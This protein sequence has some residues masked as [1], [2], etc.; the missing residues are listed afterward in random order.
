[1]SKLP[2]LLLALLGHCTQAA[3]KQTLPNAPP[4]TLPPRA[5]KPHLRKAS[6][7]FVTGDFNGDQRSDTVYQHTFSGLTKTEADSL[8]DP[9][10]VDQDAVVEWLSQHDIRIF[11]TL[12]QQAQ[13]TL[14][15]GSGQG[16][17]CLLNIGDNN[18]DK[19]DELAFVVDY[20]DFSQVTSCTIATRCAG[21]WATLK[22]F[23]IHEGAFEL[24]ADTASAVPAAA[25]TEI[26]GFLEKRKGHWVYTDYLQNTQEAVEN[27][28]MKKLRLPRCQ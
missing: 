24:P 4:A 5:S 21:K 20:Y 2:L 25:A 23:S 1:M 10:R 6:K 13:D 11:L 8:I 14:W 3:K 28:K 19:K 27:V 15:A 12:G 22:E 7:L 26:K 16:L 18:G 17:Y 9:F